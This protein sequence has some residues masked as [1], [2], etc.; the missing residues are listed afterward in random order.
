MTIIGVPET[1]G[2]GADVTKPLMKLVE[3]FTEIPIDY[4]LN[5]F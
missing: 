1:P 2:A 3:A 4:N 5:M